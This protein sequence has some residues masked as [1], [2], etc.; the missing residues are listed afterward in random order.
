MRFALIVFALFSLPLAL[1]ASQISSSN[2]NASQANA[3]ISYAYR[4]V[5]VV[6]ESGYLIFRPD[7]V[8]SYKY[9]SN[10]SALY[11]SSPDAAVLDAQTALAIAQQQYSSMSAYRSESLPFVAAFTLLMLLALLK[12]MVP[13]NRKAKKV[14]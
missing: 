2:Y 8:A 10:A 6:N 4:Y 9:L 11:K 13:L 3:T 12:V 7:L 5:N 1:H 14:A